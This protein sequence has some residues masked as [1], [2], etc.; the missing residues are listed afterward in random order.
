MVLGVKMYWGIVITM[1]FVF[2]GNLYSQSLS[3]FKEKIE[4]TIC[5]SGFTITG[6][7]YFLNKSEREINQNFYYPFVIN[8]NFQFPDS[9]IIENKNSIP[10]SYIKS[11]KGIFFNIK[12]LPEDTSEFTAFY[13]QKNLVNKAEYILTTT[14][15]WNVPL[16]KAEYT[17]NIPNNLKLKSISLQPDSIKDNSSYKSYFITKDNFMPVV[18]LIVEWGK[19]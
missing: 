3:F 4:M 10:V 12:T 7:Y 1:L 15:N 6:K 13:R 16:Q 11:K 17:V 9:I 18:N 19:E 2:W 14:Q 5:D 8:E